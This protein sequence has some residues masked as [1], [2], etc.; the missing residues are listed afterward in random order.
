MQKYNPATKQKE[1]TKADNP[2]FIT[3]MKKKFPKLDTPLLV[4][5]SNSLSTSVSE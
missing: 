1:I 2:D 5:A 4:S 3:M